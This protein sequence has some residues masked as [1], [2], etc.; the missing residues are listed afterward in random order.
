MTD[1]DA[2]ARQSAPRESPA[3]ESPP[4]ESAPRASAAGELPDPELARAALAAVSEAV[5]GV[6]GDLSVPTVLERLAAAAKRLVDAR[7]A[8]IGVPDEGSDGFA[9][10]IHVGMADDLVEAIGPLPRTHGLLG[11]MLLD[12]VPYRTDDVRADPRFSWWPSAHP[13]MRSFLGVPIVYKGDIVGAFYLADKESGE[14]FTDA[15]ESL[16]GLLAAHAAIAIENARLY[17]QSRELSIVEERNRIALELHDATA[18]TLFSIS[19]AAGTALGYLETDPR[20]AGEELATVR[21]LAGNAATELRALIFALRPPSLD[22]D[23]LLPTLRKQLDLLGRTHALEVALDAD[24]VVALPPEVEADLYRVA[25]EAL[26]N[27]VRHASATSVSVRVEQVA[28]AEGGSR[29]TL[30]VADDGAGF[31]P[32]ARSI[33]GH[34]LG[35]TSMLARAARHG[36][37]T[38]VT[39]APGRG[40]TVTAEIPIP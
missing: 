27:V 19:L 32:Q 30:T 6:A 11:S 22:R 17:E 4:R 23:G 40:T 39:S 31:D 1:A 12:P 14:R 3:Q 24:G 26:N 36:G 18:Q 15:D 10:F 29:V 9:Q 38:Q 5:L 21:Q 33:R 16:I 37:S 34:R 8:A 25:Q 28:R 20:R 13:R 2:P 35:L 7:Y